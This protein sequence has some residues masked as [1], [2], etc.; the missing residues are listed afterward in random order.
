MIPT[1]LPKIPPIRK[2]N[3][4]RKPTIPEDGN[5]PKNHKTIIAIPP[6]ESI[7]LKICI[8]LKVFI[9]ILD[10]RHIGKNKI[11]FSFRVRLPQPSVFKSKLLDKSAIDSLYS[12]LIILKL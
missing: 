4:D 1:I 9:L 11:S 6:H 10:E 7:K 2:I 3:I 8:K 5:T 12:E